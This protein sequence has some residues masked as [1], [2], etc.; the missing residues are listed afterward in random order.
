MASMML[1]Y[2]W[3]VCDG[4]GSACDRTFNNGFGIGDVLRF[5]TARILVNCSHFCWLRI[6]HVKL[7]QRPQAKR[8]PQ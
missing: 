2:A 4:L 8:A 3:P 5:K 7:V 1:V 6:T